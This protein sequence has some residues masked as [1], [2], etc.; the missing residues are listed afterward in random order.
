MSAMRQTELRECRDKYERLLQS[1]SV[2]ARNEWDARLSV[3][4]N[5]NA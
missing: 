3:R 2:A 5:E 1:L 4:S